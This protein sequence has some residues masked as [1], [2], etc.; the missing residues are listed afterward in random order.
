MN[1]YFVFENGTL[2]DMFR[3]NN[4]DAAIQRARENVVSDKSVYR[5]FRTTG[6]NTGFAPG[7]QSVKFITERVWYTNK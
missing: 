2:I 3:T 4:E 7:G 5:L 6:K 1:L